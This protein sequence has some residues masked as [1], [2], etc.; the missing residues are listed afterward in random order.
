[1]SSFTPQ[2]IGV[3][4]SATFLIPDFI[5]DNNCGLEPIAYTVTTLEDDGGVS[6]GPTFVPYEDSK[7]G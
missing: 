6:E 7:S 2:T 1:M 3:A 5:D 4:E